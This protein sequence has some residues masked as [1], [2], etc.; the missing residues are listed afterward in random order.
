MKSARAGEGNEAGVAV[1]SVEQPAGDV[2]GDSTFPLRPLLRPPSASPD[3]S[4]A[5]PFA[6][7]SEALGVAPAGAI[8]RVGEGVWRERIVL[9]R[10]VTLV[11]RG[12]GRT[13]IIPPPSNVAAI[14]AHRL[15][16]VELRG[17]SVEGARIGVL[18]SEGIGHRIENVELRDCAEA[19][20][21]A[22]DAWIAVS[23]VVIADVGA[24]S[25]GVGVEF[26]RG[27]IEARRMT[28]A[29]AGRRAFLLHAARGLLIDVEVRDA[30]LSAVQVTDG[31]DVRVVGGVFERSA[32][33]AL[34]AGGARLR[35]EAARILHDEFAVTANRGAEVVVSGGELTDYS[36]AG[37]AFLNAGGSVEK[38]LIARGGT[39]AGISITRSGK[40]SPVR[41]VDNRLQDPGPMGVHITESVVNASGN[42]ITGARLDAEMDMGDGIYVQ[43]SELTLE[44]N[45]LR[46]NAGSG[47]AAL[48]SK[49]RLSENAFIANGRA[50]VLLLEES[51]GTATRNLF[52]R[53]AQSGV[54]VGERAS[55]SLVENRFGGNEK[56]DVDLGCGR[57][58][59]GTARVGQGN[60]FETAMRT[61]S[62]R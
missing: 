53:N 22:R 16:R 6:T 21:R 47:V 10:P 29:R 50:G 42:S 31:A 5:R 56:F 39:D 35:V 23:N 2:I 46:R 55:A 60:T 45:V 19:G 8:L 4:A 57:G 1:L 30:G 14:E 44:G 34:Y 58:L 7:I 40:Q 49:A 18:I 59:A 20:L 51:Q 32:G 36:V 61:R 12:E 43:D 28:L 52:A 15:D 33:S 17:L 24:G 13:R 54:E 26:E 62:C 11:G 41:L 25:S 48:R 37:V 9:V 27:S 38:A 3:G